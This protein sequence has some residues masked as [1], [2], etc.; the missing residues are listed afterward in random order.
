MEEEGIECMEWP[1]KSP[2]LNPIENLW[3]QLGR[4]V[5]AHTVPNTTLAELSQFVLQ[6][7]NLLPLNNINRL[8]NTM[9]QRCQECIAANGGHTHY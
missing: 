2:D 4:K 8:I 7:W 1:A 6:E 9:R 5:S 3:D